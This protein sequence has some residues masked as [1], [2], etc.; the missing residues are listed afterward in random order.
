[1]LLIRT[2]AAPAEV[3]ADWAKPRLVVSSQGRAD[4]GKAEAVF[5]KR[6]VPYWPTWPNGAV[7]IRS[8]ST[9]LVAE[10][11]RSTNGRPI[12]IGV[13]RAA[14]SFRFLPVDGTG[15]TR[16]VQKL[17][18]KK[19]DLKKPFRFSDLEILLRCRGAARPARILT[20]T[21]NDP[22]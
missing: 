8:H 7:T 11:A 1:M 5:K 4:L 14:A 18:Q 9:G 13:I 2:A 17:K 6:G 20:G 15:V 21:P 10:T 19:L 3:I 16:S 22:K 12:G